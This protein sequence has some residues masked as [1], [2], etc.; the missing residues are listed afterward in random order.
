MYDSLRGDLGGE[1]GAQGGDGGKQAALTVLE[2]L[3][4]RQTGRGIKSTYDI[5]DI[6]TDI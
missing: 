4:T 2:A 1:M 5:L 6:L 3:C